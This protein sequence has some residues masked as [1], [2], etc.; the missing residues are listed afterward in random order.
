MAADDL[1]AQVGRCVLTRHA[2]VKSAHNFRA[3]LELFYAQRGQHIAH[4]FLA[5]LLFADGF[6]ITTPLHGGK[7]FFQ[8][9]LQGQKLRSRLIQQA[10]LCGLPQAMVRFGLPSQPCGYFGFCALN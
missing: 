2:R 10:R 6:H 1:L 8:P 9:H 4:S 7:D 3:G 5:N